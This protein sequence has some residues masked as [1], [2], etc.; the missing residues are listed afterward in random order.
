MIEK[1][2]TCV[3]QGW[4]VGYSGTEGSSSHS[5]DRNKE[6]AKKTEGSPEMKP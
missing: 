5:S 4:G 1:T 2:A 3:S 6:T